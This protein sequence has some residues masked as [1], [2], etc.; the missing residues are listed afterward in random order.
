MEKN[1]EIPIF[2]N[3]SL[4]ATGITLIDAEK[5]ELV[6]RMDKEEVTFKLCTYSKNPYKFREIEEVDVVIDQEKEKDKI[7]KKKNNIQKVT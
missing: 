2:L 7:K 6:M 3:K 1:N 5:R 4:L